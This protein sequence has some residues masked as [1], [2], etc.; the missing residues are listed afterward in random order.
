MV[1]ENQGA[2]I[3]HLEIWLNTTIEWNNRTKL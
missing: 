2:K 1:H 3:K